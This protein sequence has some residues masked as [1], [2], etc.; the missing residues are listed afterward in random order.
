MIIKDRPFFQVLVV[1]SIKI[2]VMIPLLLMSPPD[3]KEKWVPILAS[4]FKWGASVND[5]SNHSRKH[6]LYA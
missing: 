5:D 4:E 2:S 6:F 3:I 1:S